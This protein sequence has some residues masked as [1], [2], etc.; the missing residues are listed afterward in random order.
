M[1]NCGSENESKSIKRRYGMHLMIKSK[2]DY[3]TLRWG[4]FSRSEMYIEPI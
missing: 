2:I 1:D 3:L 4:I